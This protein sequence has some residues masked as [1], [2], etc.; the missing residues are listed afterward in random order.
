M[1]VLRAVRQAGDSARIDSQ[2]LREFARRVRLF[3]KFAEFQIVGT[4]V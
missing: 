3:I 2:P 4:L 1:G